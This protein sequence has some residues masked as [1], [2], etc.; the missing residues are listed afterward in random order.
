MSKFNKNDGT[1]NKEREAE[2]IIEDYG[3]WEKCGF[4]LKE[5]TLDKKRQKEGIDFLVTD[6]NG[7]VYNIDLKT[8]IGSCYDMVM[9]DFKD[10]QYFIKGKGLVL[11]LYQNGFFTNTAN[12]KTDF[13]LYILKDCDGVFYALVP[14]QWIHEKSVELRGGYKDIYI[15]DIHKREY[16]ESG[17]KK[18][19]T[20]TSFNGSGVYVKLPYSFIKL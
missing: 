19:K 4:T 11:E 8:Q 12:K 17:G 2:Q 16:V 18:L 3:I 5:K 10:P 14:Y 1:C 20:H 6:E 9:D 7:D 15:G 13:V